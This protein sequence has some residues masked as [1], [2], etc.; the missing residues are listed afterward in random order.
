MRSRSTLFQQ[1]KGN[2]KFLSMKVSV[3]TLT[4]V[5]VGLWDASQRSYL[6][7]E[8]T[9]CIAI[10][11][12]SLGFEDIRIAF[13]FP[14]S[15]FSGRLSHICNQGLHKVPPCES[16]ESNKLPLHSIP[17]LAPTNRFFAGGILSLILATA[18]RA[19]STTFVY[20]SPLSFFLLWLLSHIL[21]VFSRTQAR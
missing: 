18:E 6:K 17:F 10:F 12:I 11:S 9:S 4:M 13:G 21:S 7:R 1:A 8:R 16:Q 5:A 19:D 2:S 15:T 3:I 14:T 20:E